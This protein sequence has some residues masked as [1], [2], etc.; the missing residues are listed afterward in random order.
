MATRVLIV[1]DHLAIR[2]GI[3][4]LLAP[5]GDFV[6]VGE[7]VDG[8]DGVEKALELSSRS[9]AAPRSSTSAARS[10]RRR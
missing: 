1:D 5:E 7:A 2:E 9:G 8:A 3:R 6:V 4:S 10:D